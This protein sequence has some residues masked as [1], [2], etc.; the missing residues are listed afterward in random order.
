MLI[1][2]CIDNDEDADGAGGAS[3]AISVIDI[4]DAFGYNEITMS[5]AEFMAYIKTY[6]PKVK[7]HLELIGKADR[8]PE[9]QKGATAFVKDIVSKFD[10][11]QIFVGKEF[12]TEGGYAYCYY[13]NQ[14]D[15]GPTF[16]YFVDGM[17]E[18]K[19][20]IIRRK[21]MR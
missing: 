20:W 7:T 17:K 18:E 15:T 10:E 14:E 16:F 11:V 8:I 19:F 1:L 21:V 9:F 3:N 5:K 4:V 2:W 6:L 12:N 13:V